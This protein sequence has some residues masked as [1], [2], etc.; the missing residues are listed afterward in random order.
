MEVLKALIATGRIVDIM[1][2][3][4]GMEIVAITLYRSARGG[5]IPLLPLLL[6]IGAGGSLMLALRA[7]LTDAGWQWVAVFLVSSL[8]F[9]AADQGQ[10]WEN[11]GNDTD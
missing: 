4:L 9:H 8:V 1:V 10:R 2:L 11:P 5:G 3:F 7:S 6:N